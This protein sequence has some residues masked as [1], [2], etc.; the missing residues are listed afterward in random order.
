MNTVIAKCINDRQETRRSFLSTFFPV[1]PAA[2]TFRNQRLHHASPAHDHDRRP[3][4]GQTTPTA[5]LQITTLLTLALLPTMT[6]K[7]RQSSI[8]SLTNTTPSPSTPSTLHDTLPLPKLIVFDLDYTLWPFWC[9]THVSGSIK[10]TRDG[11][12]SAYDSHGGSYAFYD[13]VPGILTSLKE[14]GVEVGCAS[15]TSA[16]DVAKALLTTLRC[17]SGS[18]DADADAGTAAAPTAWSLFD[19]K[20]MYPGS[21]TKHFQRLHKKSGVPYTEMLFFDDEARNRNVEELGVVMQLVR[22]GVTVEEVDRGVQEWRKRNGRMSREGQGEALGGE[23][24]RKEL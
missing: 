20:E 22:D 2:Q 10:G 17:T 15:R 14:R 12:L 23:A 18:D 16:S 9:D 7:N 4:N 6:R 21:K 3:H 19:Y 13:D 5:L 11:G 1:V 24:E 8:S